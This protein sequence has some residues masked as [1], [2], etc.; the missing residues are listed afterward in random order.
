MATQTL[1]GSPVPVDGATIGWLNGSTLYVAGNSPTNNQCTGTMAVTCG[2]LD[3]VDLGSMTVTSSVMITDGYHNRIDMSSNGQLFIG[4]YNCTTIG[5][6]NNPQG[7]VR[8]CL[9][10][11]DTTK[12]GNTTAIIPPDNGD[13]TA[14]QNFTSRN[15]EYVAEGG[16]LRV[17]DTTKDILLVNGFISTG[18]VTITGKIIDVKAVDF[19]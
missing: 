18:T 9:S 6:V 10:I 17:Y 1:V 16:N 12:S 19:F 15:A 8:G 2:R 5:N 4:S 7:E 3:A 11:F 14:F 13:V